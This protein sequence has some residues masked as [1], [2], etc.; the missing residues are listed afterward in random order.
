M[1][2]LYQRENTLALLHE[3]TRTDG[4]RSGGGHAGCGRA[5]RW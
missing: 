1:S 5:H 4:L 3:Y 2:D